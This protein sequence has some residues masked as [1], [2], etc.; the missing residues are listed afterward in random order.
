VHNGACRLL[1]APL[2]LHTPTRKAAQAILLQDEGRVLQ[3]AFNVKWAEMR[4]HK[5]SEWLCRAVLYCT[6]YRSTSIASQFGDHSNSNTHAHCL[7][8][9]AVNLMTTSCLA[10][11]L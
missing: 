4:A 10:R 2:Q 3:R 11:Q 6:C 5:V 1:Y 7:C 8:L 9:L